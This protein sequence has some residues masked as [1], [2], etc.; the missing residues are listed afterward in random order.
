[1][2]AKKEDDVIRKIDPTIRRDINVATFKKI[3]E[4][5]K[6]QLEPVYKSEIVRNLGINYNSLNL[7]L[8]MMNIK[9]DAEGRITLKRAGKSFL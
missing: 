2:A 1:M 7:A 9:V 4:Y 5:L 6:D 3:N 8:Q